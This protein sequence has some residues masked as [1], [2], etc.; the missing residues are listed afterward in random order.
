MHRRSR[1][2]LYRQGDR[3]HERFMA[4]VPFRAK[5]V[6]SDRRDDQTGVRPSIGAVGLG[7]GETIITLQDMLRVPL[8][9]EVVF[10]QDLPKQYYRPQ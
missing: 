8:D 9:L 5:G 3:G 1:A 6:R 4:V 7:A 2:R 10:V